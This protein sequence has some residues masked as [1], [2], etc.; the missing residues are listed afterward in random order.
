V[1]LH[2]PQ[3]KRELLASC[4]EELTGTSG[5]VDV[6]VPAG[7]SGG[8]VVRASAYNVLRQRSDPLETVAEE[9]TRPDG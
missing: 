6:P 4:P 7:V 3:D 9:G 8:V 5:T 2:R 1:T